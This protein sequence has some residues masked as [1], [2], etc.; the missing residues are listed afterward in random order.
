MTVK[1]NSLTKSIQNSVG[2]SREVRTFTRFAVR[3]LSGMRGRRVI[4]DA[5]FASG[6]YHLNLLTVSMSERYGPSVRTFE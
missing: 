2:A 4:A 3:I 6:T 5:V 1:P